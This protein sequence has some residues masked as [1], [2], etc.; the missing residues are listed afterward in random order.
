MAFKAFIKAFLGLFNGLFC[1]ILGHKNPFPSYQFSS[2]RVQNVLS[3]IV[4]VFKVSKRLTA[5]NSAVIVIYYNYY[6]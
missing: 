2:I 3:K 4:L 5:L 6:K 1:Q